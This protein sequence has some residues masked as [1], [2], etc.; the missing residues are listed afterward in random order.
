RVHAGGV[1]AAAQPGGPAVVVEPAGKR[2]KR[3][4]FLF[5]GKG[6]VIADLGPECLMDR[7]HADAALERPL[8]ARLPAGAGGY[9]AGLV[10][11]PGG[12]L[13]GRIP[14]L[15]GAVHAAR[16]L[17]AAGTVRPGDAAARGAAGRR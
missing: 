17:P 6:M 8:L 13:P 2:D 7:S 3:P 11:A 5:P 1:A 15:A 16:N 4:F 12:P 9:D 10:H 14:G